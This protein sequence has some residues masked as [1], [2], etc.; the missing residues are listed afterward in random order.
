M[1][2]SALQQVY[3]TKRD[4][5]QRTSKNYGNKLKYQMIQGS[6]Q[7]LNKRQSIGN[8]NPHLY[9]INRGETFDLTTVTEKLHPYQDTATR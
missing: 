6:S 2:G 3:G 5:I 4:L 9:P 1:A 7:I 8:K